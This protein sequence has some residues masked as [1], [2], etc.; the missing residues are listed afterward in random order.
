MN[1]NKLTKVELISKLKRSETKSDSSTK[2]T[3]FNQIKSY[4]YQIWD[5]ITIFKNILL[6]L[7]FI[8]LI[9]QIFRKYRIFRTLWKII[10]TI[11]MSIFGISLLDNFGLEFVQNFLIELKVITGN[12]INYLSNTNFYLFL[13]KLFSQKEEVTN[14]RGPLQE[15]SAGMG[16]ENS[17]NEGKT[18][19]NIERSKGNSRISDWIKPEEKPLQEIEDKIHKTN[20]IKYFII[21]GTIIIISS[22]GWIYWDEVK[23]TSESILEWYFFSGNKI[24]K[25]YYTK[26]IGN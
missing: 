12:I 14:S 21:G 13:E 19:E 3:L 4:L 23:S 8:S 2:L 6:K 25:N 22:L 26:Y 15:K 24:A 16:R 18:S 1:L 10:N 7:T 20:Y 11:V 5:L 9:I 17:T